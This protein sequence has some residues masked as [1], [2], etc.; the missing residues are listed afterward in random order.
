M[1]VAGEESFYDLPLTHEVYR[2]ARALDEMAILDA[3]HEPMPFYRVDLPP[4]AISEVRTSLGASP[5][6]QQQRTEAGPDL[7]ISLQG[8]RTD[9]R[10]KRPENGEPPSDVVAFVIDARQLDH[11][12][13][14]MELQ[15]QPL[16]RP[17]LMNVT[18][19]HSDD[20]SNWRRVGDG[21][22]AALSI[23]DAS[24]AHRTIEIA[25]RPGGYYR[26]T[27]NRSV[28]DWMLERVDIITSSL[29]EQ[30]TFERVGLSALP[31]EPEAANARYFDAGGALPVTGADLVMPGRNQWVNASI[32]AG[33]SIDGPWRQVHGR[34][35]FYDVEFEGERL[36]SEPLE[37][38]RVEAR[39]WR[40]VFGK[41]ST[42]QAV[43][44][45]LEYPEERLRFSANGQ[46]PYQLVGGTLAEE[47]G[48][49]PT[50]AAVMK[51][52]S[53]DESKIA[54]ARLG[55]RV[56]LGGPGVLEI[57][58][59]FPWRTVYLWVALFAA[60]AVVGFMALKLARDMFASD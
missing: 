13:K 31:A 23:E 52:L 1:Q 12:P 29:S 41:D 43:E 22:V 26:V 47:A 27:W 32:Y 40:V 59:E 36:R 17:F 46:A 39:F 20:L 24:L 14:A 19:E 33:N 44:L 56:N 5:I 4:A 60:A 10:I 11:S 54:T 28:A 34:R 6:Y 51:A 49:D 21:S 37:I 15:W 57:P 45:S 35:L 58:T 48:P 38:G 9:V 30:A 50:L 2:Y 42:V 16:E 25:G 8:D 3:N 53:P 18:V 7:S 55:R